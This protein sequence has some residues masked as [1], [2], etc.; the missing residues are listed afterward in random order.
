MTDKDRELM[1]QK[2]QTLSHLTKAM[3]AREQQ[4]L[5]A[6][7]RRTK[8]KADKEQQEMQTLRQRVREMEAQRDALLA[9]LKQAENITAY[10]AGGMTHA[11]WMTK[12]A[13][14]AHE[15]VVAAINSVEEN[16]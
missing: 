10:A 4:E 5:E 15:A 9:A 16:T 12:R 13:I 2:M 3:L 7:S 1:Q 8:E 6:L 14:E 11:D